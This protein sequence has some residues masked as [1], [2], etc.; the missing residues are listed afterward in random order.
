[1]EIGISSLGYIIDIARTATLNDFKELLLNAT[2][3]C[4]NFAEKNGINIVELVIEPPQIFNDEYKQKFIDLV[5]S[6][7]IKKQ[8]HGPYIDL[9][10]CSHNTRIS[11]VSIESNIE[12]I[13][14]CYQI[15]VNLLTIHPGLANFM[16]TSIREL[17]KD[18][19]KKAIHKILDF[20]N[21]QNFLICLENMPKK[22][23][24]MTDNKN[25]DEVYTTI[26][27]EDLK[28]TY[29]TSHFYM[30][31]GNVSNLW[32]EYHQI[33]KNVHLVDNFS[34]DSDTHP[35]LGSGKIDFKE[36]FDVLKNYNYKGPMIIELSSANSLIQS[37]NYIN[38]FL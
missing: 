13:K 5:N 18:H 36:I 6:Y 37:L 17:N 2:E 24:I 25:I 11:E 20:T 34:K 8:V 1:M 4:F 30:C 14:I 23:Y 16:L 28:I 32:D 21:N 19:L 9:S 38:K 27:R 22:A 3:Q 12:I 33:I 10:L 7:S 29:D 15:D 26:A 31:D 35:P